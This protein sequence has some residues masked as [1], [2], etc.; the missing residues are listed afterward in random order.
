M[1]S[2]LWKALRNSGPRRPQR[3]RET[4]SRLAVER[5]EDRTLLSGG[6]AG[7]P[8]PSGGRRTGDGSGLIAVVDQ[9][10]GRGL[11]G[12]GYPLAPVSGPSRP[13]PGTVVTQTQPTTMVVSTSGSPGGPSPTLTVVPVVISGTSGSTP[14]GSSTSL[15][16]PTSC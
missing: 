11:S 14:G 9:R 6:L 1:F 5:L 12:P 13:D 8:G 2:A 7:G 10:G 3:P 16:G 15:A 4:H